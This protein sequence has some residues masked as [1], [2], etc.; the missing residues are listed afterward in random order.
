MKTAKQDVISAK[1]GIRKKHHWMPVFTGMTKK[2]YPYQRLPGGKIYSACVGLRAADH[3]PDNG[4][5]CRR[6][7]NL[8]RQNRE[9]MQK[10]VKASD[11]FA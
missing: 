1:A 10:I 7:F 6:N 3:V 8:L 11:V 9:G 5:T 4:I 2:T